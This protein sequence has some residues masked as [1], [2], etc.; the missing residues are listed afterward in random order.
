MIERFVKVT[1]NNQFTILSVSEV[2]DKDIDRSFNDM[3]HR[4]LDCSLYERVCMPSI[5]NHG[6]AMLVDESGIL[7]SKE[8]N[9]FPWFYYSGMNF[10]APIVGDVLFVGEHRIGEFHEIDF[11][12]LNQGQIDFLT[13]LF[14]NFIVMLEDKK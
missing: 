8:P 6:I 14:K 2:P 10:C 3:V 4:E 5:Y 13:R 1:T 7:K 12:G 9:L 11:C